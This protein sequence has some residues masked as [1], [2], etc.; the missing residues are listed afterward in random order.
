[1]KFVENPGGG[2]IWF[3]TGASS[4]QGYAD[5]RRAH[6]VGF[7]GMYSERPRNNARLDDLTETSSAYT[8]G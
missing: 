8:P 7:I 6:L 1:M 2:G 5:S 4:G 3:Q